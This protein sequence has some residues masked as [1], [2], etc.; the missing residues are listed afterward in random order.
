M[1]PRCPKAE[2]PAQTPYELT[3][4]TDRGS[5]NLV[6]LVTMP[7]DSLNDLAALLRHGEGADMIDEWEVAELETEQGRL[8]RRSLADLWEQAMHRGDQVLV[9][10]PFGR[11]TGAV[12]FVGHD[13]A[14]VIGHEMCWDLQLDTCVMQPIRSPDG[15]HTV[16]GGSRTFRARLAEFESTGEEVTVLVFDKEFTGSIAVAATDHLVL[17]GDPPNVIPLALIS[18]IRRPV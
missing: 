1:S 16:W 15:G 9:V 10:A 8:R 12:D 14:T 6:S 5:C 17:T 18:A 13:F 4:A 11:F 3:D 2:R 7:S